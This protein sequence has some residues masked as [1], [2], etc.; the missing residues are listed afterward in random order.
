MSGLLLSRES[1]V[2]PSL[3]GSNYATWKKNMRILLTRMGLLQFIQEGRPDD[4]DHTWTRADG[5]AFSEIYFRCTSDLQLCLD[6]S[7][8]AA[9]DAWALFADLYQSAT[10]PN[11]LDLNTRFAALQQRPGQ[12]AVQF[13]NQDLKHVCCTL[14]CSNSNW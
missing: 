6:D 10:I 11:L 2:F 7:E 13:I 4:A 8:M 1:T 12:P 14:C 9:Y 5:W 3:D